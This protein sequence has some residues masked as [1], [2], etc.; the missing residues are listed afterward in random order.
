[1]NFE[2]RKGILFIRFPGYLSY[3]EGLE[4]KTRIDSFLLENGI[5]YFVFNFEHVRRMDELV[6]KMIEEDYQKV[7]SYQGRVLFCLNPK[8]ALSMK[9]GRL[10]QNKEIIKNEI[11][12]FQCIQI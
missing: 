1:M 8:V 4:F 5:R 11:G 7:L 6:M 9:H 10:L 3:S 2:F 12:A